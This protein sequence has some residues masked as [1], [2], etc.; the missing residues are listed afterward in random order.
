MIDH[1]KNFGYIFLL[2]ILLICSACNKSDGERQ[3]IP[4][5]FEFPF[6]KIGK[7]KTFIY[8][9][10]GQANKTFFKDVNSIIEGNRKFIIY[11]NYTPTEKGDSAK[12]TKNHNLVETFIF[13]SPDD[14]R[15]LDFPNK[16]KG[17]IME[18]SIIRTERKIG[19]RL[20]KI[21]F[22][23]E[24]DFFFNKFSGRISQRYCFK[25]AG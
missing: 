2:L 6:E 5:E 16:V 14:S 13:L 23:G 24:K 9:Q 15:N 22:E 21:V 20:S 11:Q 10:E 4:N 7:G 3:F 1:I 8:K 17:R 25:M 18:D 19:I 12:F